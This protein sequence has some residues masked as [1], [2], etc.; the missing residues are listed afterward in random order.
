MKASVNEVTG[1]LLNLAEIAG[2]LSI[3]TQDC[4]SWTHFEERLCHIAESLADGFYM[5]DET[6]RHHYSF[7]VIKDRE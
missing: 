2:H 6:G 5:S 3:N 4:G 1:E 7:A